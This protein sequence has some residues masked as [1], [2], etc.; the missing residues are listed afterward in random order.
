MS[1]KPDKI[2]FD[3][4]KFQMLLLICHDL[5][6]GDIDPEIKESIKWFLAYHRSIFDQRIQFLTEEINRKYK[7]A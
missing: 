1:K 7:G 5:H 6:D 3:R 2:E 4:E